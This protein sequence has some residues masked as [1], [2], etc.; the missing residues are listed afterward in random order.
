M[1]S[2]IY[3]GHIGNTVLI[4]NL[5]FETK[6]EGKWRET[7]YKGNLILDSLKVI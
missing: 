7:I 2:Y 1:L 5:Q 4:S 3:L 6:S